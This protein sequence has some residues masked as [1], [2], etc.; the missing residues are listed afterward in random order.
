M[1]LVKQ[2]AAFG[3]S[4]FSEQLAALWALTLGVDV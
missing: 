4:P 1:S 3:L 2:L